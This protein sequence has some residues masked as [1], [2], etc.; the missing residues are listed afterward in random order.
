MNKNIKKNTGI[1]KYE[2]KYKYYSQ[3]NITKIYLHEYAIWQI[4]CIG[5]KEI[6]TLGY[7]FSWQIQIQ[8]YLVSLRQ[9]GMHFFVCWQNRPNINTN[10]FKVTKNPTMDMNRLTG[11]CKYKYK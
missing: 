10:I 1:C 11:V 8:I 7:F 2:Y 5:C 4:C 9:I 6:D 3:T